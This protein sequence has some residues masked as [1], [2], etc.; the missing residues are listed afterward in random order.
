MYLT[1]ILAQAKVLL[2]VKLSP[3]FSKYLRTNQTCYFL[4]LKQNYKDDEKLPKDQ[5]PITSLHKS[6]FS[7]IVYIQLGSCPLYRRH[8]SIKLYLKS[9]TR[10]RGRA[11]HNAEHGA[12][13]KELKA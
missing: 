7:C 11:E 13:G 6:P 3:F 8:Y 9:S 4:L 1:D 12:C 2:M 5:R 10:K